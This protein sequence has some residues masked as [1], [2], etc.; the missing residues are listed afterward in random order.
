MTGS[1]AKNGCHYG[2]STYAIANAK[3]AYPKRQLGSP[4]E[5]D[6]S[7]RLCAKTEAVHMNKH[8][9]FGARI[10]AIVTQN[11]SRSFARGTT[12]T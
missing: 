12:R 8:H 4:F 10:W 9:Q 11:C 2:T 5:S 1:S 3:R 6:T 7:K